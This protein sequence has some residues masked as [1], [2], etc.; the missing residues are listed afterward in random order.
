MLKDTKI[1]EIFHNSL[2]KEQQLF[3]TKLCDAIDTQN[4]Q[5]LYPI[6]Y[7]LRNEDA[8]LTRLIPKIIEFVCQSMCF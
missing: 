5:V 7:A 3:F 1:R 2:S 6:L 4:T 8:G